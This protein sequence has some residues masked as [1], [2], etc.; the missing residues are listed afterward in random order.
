MMLTW[1]DVFCKFIIIMMIMPMEDNHD[2]G[3]S[4]LPD[5]LDRR[6]DPGSDPAPAVDPVGDHAADPAPRKRAWL[7]SARPLG[8]AASPDPRW[9]GSPAAR[10]AP[11]R[12]GRG[13]QEKLRSR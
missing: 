6:L 7:H 11:D 5:R 4:H 1:P 2:R 3:A 13:I 9:R 8:E 10:Q 12:G